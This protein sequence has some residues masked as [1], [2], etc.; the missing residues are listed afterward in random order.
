MRA[1]S[2]SSH[3]QLSNKF[4]ACCCPVAASFALIEARSGAICARLI[5]SLGSGAS[6]MSWA[7]ICSL[8]VAASFAAAISRTK[9]PPGEVVIRAD[10]SGE[11]ALGRR[12]EVL[13][14]VGVEV[15]DGHAP[16]AAAS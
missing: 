5:T 3:A 16:A 10:L 8:P 12:E 7:A 1:S 2:E 13:A 11:T 14:V 9:S 6:A 15:I 4:P